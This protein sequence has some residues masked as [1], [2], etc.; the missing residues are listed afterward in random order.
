[1][2]KFDIAQGNERPKSSL[3]NPSQPGSTVWLAHWSDHSNQVLES[4]ANGTQTT[5]ADDLDNSYYLWILGVFGAAQAVLSFLRNWYFFTTC[6]RGSMA[7]HD[8]L[9]DV[10]IRAR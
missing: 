10:I 8:L 2:P 3:Y 9:F 5:T 1:L 7:I 6:A 4:A